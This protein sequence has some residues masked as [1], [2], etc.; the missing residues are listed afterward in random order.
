MKRILSLLLLPGL[1]LPGL[2]TGCGEKEPDL[3]PLVGQT[4]E[5]ALVELEI[6]PAEL[7]E[8]N[9]PELTILP[10]TWVEED[11]CIA[12]D[13]GNTAL[14]DAVQAILDEMQADGTLDAIIAKYISAD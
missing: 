14:L 6:D 9:Y 1:L 5:E 13:E 4:V 12:V 7:P 11:Y 3:Y 8:E 2:L 10:G